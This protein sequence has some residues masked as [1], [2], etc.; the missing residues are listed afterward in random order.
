MPRH[1]L[2]ATGIAEWRGVTFSSKL[3]LASPS[4]KDSINCRDVD[5]AGNCYFDDF[6]PEGT[7]GFK[8]FDIA[9]QKVWDT[10]TSLRPRVRADI[11]NVF[12]W[13]N[14][15]DYNTNRGNPG[16]PNPTFGQRTSD[17]TVWPPRMFKL[18]VG[19]DW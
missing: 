5:L 16:N 13:A 8:Q 12:N 6:I 3:T 4:P 11:L 9:V 17:A 15:L 14:Y 1:R 7:I 18:S 2:V 10:G 19:F